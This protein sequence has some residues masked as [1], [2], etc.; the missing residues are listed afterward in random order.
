MKNFLLT[1]AFLLGISVQAVLAAGANFAVISDP[2]FYDTDLG[3]TGQAFEAYLAQDRKMLQEGEAILKAAIQTIRAKKPDFVIIPGDLTK[4]GELTSHQKLA[5]HLSVLEKSGIKV[6]VAPGNH[7]INNPH[8]VSFQGATTTPVPSVTP[9]EFASVYNEFGYGEALYRDP[10]S[11]SYIAE[12]V[13]GTWVFAIDSCKYE[14]NMAGHYPETSGA[15]RPATMSWIL[16]KLAQ[17]RSLGK[18]VLG[19]MH[20]GVTEHYQGQSLAFGQYVVDDWANVST[21]LASAGLKLV[22]T[23][24]YHANDISQSMPANKGPFLYDIETGSLVTYPSPFRIV[25]LMAGKAAIHTEYVKRIAYNTGGVPFPEY[26]RNFLMEG[27]L[28]IAQYTLKNQYGLSDEMAAQLAPLVANA[29]AAHYAGDESPDPATLATISNFL[30]SPDPTTQFLGQTLYALWT[31]LPPADTHAFLDFTCPIKLSVAGTYAS[32]VFDKGA[33]EILAHDP[34]TDRLFVSNAEANGVDVLDASDPSAPVR[35]FSIALAPYGNGVNSVAVK[36][37]IVAVA[38]EADPKQD[39]GK[40][41]FF[42]TDGNYLNAVGAGALPDMVTFTPDGNTVLAANEGEPNADYTNDPEGSV[43][44]IDISGGVAHASVINSGF[45]S[46]NSQTAALKAAGVRVFGPGATVAMDLE[47]EYIAVSADSKTAWITCQ[48]NNALAVLDIPSATVTDILAL[49][50]KNYGLVGNGLDASNKDDAVNIKPYPNLFGMVQPDAVAAFE[51]GGETY[52]ITA[53]EGDAR[54]YDGFEEES[55]ISK[56]NLDPTAFPNGAD[57]QE[58]ALLGNLKITTTLG[59]E[60][61]DGDYDKLFAFGGRSFSIFKPGPSSLDLVF[62]SGDQLEQITGAMLPNEFNSTNDENNSFDDRSDNKGPEPEGL[63]VGIVNQR[64]YAFIGLERLGGIM[65]Y[66][67]TDPAA[68]SFVQYINNR[69][70]SGNAS[71][72]TAGDLGPEGLIFIP[73]GESP[74]GK[75][76]LAV[77]NENSGTT[78]LYTVDEAVQGPQGDVNGDGILDREDIM[79]IKIH[80]RQPA[81]AFPGADMDGDGMITVLDM[82]KLVLSCTCRRCV[83]PE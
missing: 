62:D 64:T 83:C 58:K 21:T 56:I 65:V 54:E 26:A 9:E 46:Y 20:H 71:L 48:E 45:S 68:P 12:P 17:A 14:N 19:F 6:F 49:P 52:L 13:D 2:H 15:I 79:L 23:G 51:S 82:R 77:A 31:D 59:D 35:L 60:D 66:E 57:L 22:F 70:F 75:E 53:N 3:T 73:A 81:A 30:K 33:A 63:A 47:P 28:G 1:L 43:S 10:A 16:E 78:T 42:D 40:I 39:P 67:V 34:D 55:K 27:L 32:G 8:A 7:D 50:F 37:G 69:D 61:G 11:L 29:F 44:V 41:V 74:T 36:N 25:T 4:D 76:M 5:R 18:E 72:G 38:V 24:H 80:M